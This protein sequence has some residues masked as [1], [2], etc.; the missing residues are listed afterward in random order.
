MVVGFCPFS[1][2]IVSGVGRWCWATSQ[3]SSSSQR[4]PV[5]LKSGL[6][7]TTWLPPHQQWRTMSCNLLW[8]Q[9]GVTGL[10]VYKALWYRWVQGK[11]GP[12]NGSTNPAKC[13]H[14][15]T[16]R[17]RMVV[18]LAYWHSY[19]VISICFPYTKGHRFF[20]PKES[21]LIDLS[22]PRKV[23][24]PEVSQP[25]NSGHDGRWE[26][27]IKEDKGSD[28]GLI[29]QRAIFFCRRTGMWLMVGYFRG[30]QHP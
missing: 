27:V 22:L 28:I 16:L 19:S 17:L 30:H 6:L 7:Q 20:L 23:P 12:G 3:S 24:I 10:L 4:C 26:R 5:G 13:Q 11:H 8:F 2:I 21:V 9:A 1:R 18:Y 14:I 29:N 15:Q 25:Q